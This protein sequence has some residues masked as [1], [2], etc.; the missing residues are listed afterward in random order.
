MW[1]Q[2]LNIVALLFF[3]MALFFASVLKEIE[4]VH[5]FPWP[6]AEIICQPPARSNS[7]PLTFRIAHAIPEIFRGTPK[8]DLVPPVWTTA[9]PKVRKS[10]FAA[11]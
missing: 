9:T 7:M 11:A 6:P 5:S 8:V 4:D 3:L 10:R 2:F 1:K